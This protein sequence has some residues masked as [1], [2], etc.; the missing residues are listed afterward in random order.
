[1]AGIGGRYF[2][3]CNEAV[4]VTKRPADYSGVAHYAL[5]AGNAERLWN[6]SLGLIASGAPS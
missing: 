6:I 5:N 2:E 1:L 4:T 3:D